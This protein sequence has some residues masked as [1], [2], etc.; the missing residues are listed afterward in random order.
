[1]ETKFGESIP[2]QM[3]VGLEKML[4]LVFFRVETQ[5][6]TTLHVRECCSQHGGSDNLESQSEEN[7]SSRADTDQLSARNYTVCQVSVPPVD[8]WLEC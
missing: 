2:W 8:C 5:A 1:M 6:D 3:C 7:G 4:K